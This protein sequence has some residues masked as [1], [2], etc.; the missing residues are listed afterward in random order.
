MSTSMDAGDWD[1]RYAK[2]PLVWGH[3]PNQF[4]AAA[5]EHLAPGRSLDVGCGEGR[6]TIWLARRG[7]HATGVDFSPVA[8]DKAR[9]L[10]AH[11]G[12]EADFA[13]ADLTVWEPDPAM[14]DL[15]AWVYVHFPEPTRSEAV[16][17]A[18]GALRPGGTLIW[19]GHDLDNIADGVGGPQ[20]P[21][22][23]AT[24][25]DLTAMLSSEDLDIVEAR[26]VHRHIVTEV[27]H[28]DGS[29]HEPTI[30]ID[31]LVV[32]RKR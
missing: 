20:D 14:F 12:V 18:L 27:G 26:Q 5:A 19:V 6:N 24:V 21:A 10:A 9:Q 4:F 1:A 32:A 11:S 30:A 28:G 25:G 16:H 15:V 31:Q 2:S 3:D 29:P 8:I 17:R 22:V 7:W 13:V 23:L